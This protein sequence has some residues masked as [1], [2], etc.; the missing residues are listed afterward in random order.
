MSKRINEVEC[1]CPRGRRNTKDSAPLLSLRERPVLPF[2]N[3]RSFPSPGP[4][5]RDL[6]VPT[7]PLLPGES[8]A[9]RGAAP[10]RVPSGAPHACLCPLQ[11]PTVSVLG[12]RGGCAGHSGAGPG[13]SR[14]GELAPAAA[15]HS[16]RN[17]R[18]EG[19]GPNF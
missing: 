10:A 19:I 3:F 14:V 13:R 2:L 15:Q 5:A 16:I 18:V 1:S 9:A 8:A 17:N 12:R 11:T 6:Q 7:W 4:A